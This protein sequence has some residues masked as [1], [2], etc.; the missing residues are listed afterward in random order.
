MKKLL[1]ANQNT[2]LLSL[3]EDIATTRDRNS[4][5]HVIMEKVKPIVKFDDTLLLILSADL[6]YYDFV[7]TTS[8]EQ[9]KEHELYNHVISCQPISDSLVWWYLNKEENIILQNLEEL[10]TNPSFPNSDPAV[11]M[12]K[13]T[14]LWFSV[15]HKLFWNNNLI[16]LLFFHFGERQQFLAAEQSLTKAIANHVTVA[17]ANILANEELLEREREKTILLSISSA[18]SFA[19]NAV[20]LLS[21]IREKAKQLIPF[22]DTGIL[23]VEDDGQHHYDLAVNVRGWDATE[24]NKQLY[25]AGLHR[26]YHPGSYIAH[27]MSLIKEAHSPIIDDYEKSFQEFDYAFFPIIKQLGYKEG[28]I[29]ELKSG[30]KTFGTLWLNS[31]KKN[32]FHAKQFE[33]FQA[34]AD[35]VSLAVANILAS[36]EIL[37][38]EREKTLQ[39]NLSNALT[40]ELSWEG[41]LLKAMQLLQD[42]VPFDFAAVSLEKGEK[43]AKVYNFNRIGIDEYQTISEEQFVLMTGI[44]QAEYATI[45]KEIAYTKPLLLNQVELENLCRRYKSKRL[46]VQTFKVASNLVFPIKLSHDG[47]LTISLFSKQS[48]AY[49]TKHLQ[50]LDKLQNIISVTIDKLLAYEEIEKLSEQLKLENVYLQEEVQSGYNFNEFIGQS[51]AMK[52]ACKSIGL[53]AK[54]DTTVLILG[55][56][57]TGKELVA[58]AIHNASERK[59]KPLIKVNCAAL[60]PQLIESEL[61]GHER[62]AFTGAIER[63]IGKFEIANGSSIFLD[64]IGELPLELQSKLLRVLQEKEVERLGSNKIVKV[65][66]RVIA[67]TNRDLS[68]EMRQGTFRPDLFYRLN[69]FP[70][71]L[72]PLRERKEDIPSLV[73]HFIK[74]FDKKAGKTITGL[75]HKALEELM[76]YNWPGNIRELEHILERAIILSK[77]K[78][79]EDVHLPSVEKSP[80]SQSLKGYEIKSFIE[81]EKEYILHVL[82]HCNGKVSGLNGAASLLEMPDSTLASKMI[83]LGIKKQHYAD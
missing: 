14:G 77:S 36:E 12:M 76:S 11:K 10:E 54:T 70:I 22:Y 57:G 73:T 52:D 29:T 80:I 67:A 26:I 20:E 61:F 82:R 1:T 7:L 39:I 23:I 56:T 68:K 34:L 40:Q 51:G 31:K 43:I 83:K 48:A 8:L 27:V 35:Q 21:A 24:S 13:E 17:A 78:H 16:G 66:V 38:R 81:H 50:L 69:V 5:W 49:H 71:N 46:I 30:G 25:E 62:G 41:K 47:Q 72:P 18:I 74:Q 59:G 58:R 44:S 37:E 33:I 19:R 79:L 28:I 42:F 60:P 2:L 4:L 64:E 3:S 32:H 65:N 15:I 63:R 9:R 53:V 75:S 45:R 6:K 55:E